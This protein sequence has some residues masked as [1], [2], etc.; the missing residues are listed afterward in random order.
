M[1][2][3][4]GM[5]KD[6]EAEE[7]K[8]EVEEE[9]EELEAEEVKA[10]EKTEEDHEEQ[11]ADAEISLMATRVG[12]SKGATGTLTLREDALLWQLATASE[13]ELL[14]LA[15]ARTLKLEKQ[16]V[17]PFYTANRLSL[18]RKM[19]RQTLP[20]GGWRPSEEDTRAPIV[21]S[22]WESPRIRCDTGV[23]NYARK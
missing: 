14:Q 10:K 19:T 7:A 3:W 17:N 20:K 12:H 9:A 11:D 4:I 13:P 5:R 1:R 2:I 23:M 15:K 21:E 6:G 18:I 22:E 8:K 16:Q